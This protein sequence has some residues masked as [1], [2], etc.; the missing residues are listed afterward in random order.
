MD[1]VSG[2]LFGAVVSDLGIRCESVF[3]EP[4]RWRRGVYNYHLVMTCVFISGSAS[5]SRR[6]APPFPYHS[7]SDQGLIFQGMVVIYL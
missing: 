7:E 6:E 4:L 1:P 2:V 3:P 5:F